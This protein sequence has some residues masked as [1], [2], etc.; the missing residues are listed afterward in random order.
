MTGAFDAGEA[1][2]DVRLGNHVLNWGESTFIQNGVNVI[3]PFD[4]TKL[5]TPGA[6]L[7]D[8]LEPVPLVSASVAPT[9]ALSLEGFYQLDWKKTEIDPPGTY[10]STN[11]YAG[12]GGNRAFFD[13]PRFSAILPDDMGGGFGPLA[14]AMNLDF[15]AAGMSCRLASA[16]PTFGGSDCQPGF[17]PGF[18]SVTRKPG[19]R[20]RRFRPVGVRATLSRRESE[21]HRV[22]LLLR[23]PPQPLAAGQRDVR[24]ASRFRCRCRGGAGGEPARLQHHHGDHFTGYPAGHPSS[25]P[26]VHPTDHGS[27][28][29]GRACRNAAVG[30]RPAS[31]RPARTAG[32]TAADG[33]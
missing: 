26:S 12:A 21:R 1:A 23:Q 15:I 33:R 20:A 7:R 2:V 10:F 31:R 28:L 17:D 24:H 18:L 27:G 4:V 29:R 19:P 13:D 14:A 9:S 5:R 11:D 25:H 6:E 8:A 22:R 30:H 32:N 3:N 16:A